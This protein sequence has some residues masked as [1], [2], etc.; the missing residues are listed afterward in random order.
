[1]DINKAKEKIKSYCAYQ[2]RSPH[3]VIAKLKKLGQIL[4][5]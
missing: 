1:M 2:D 5:L 4:S 3:E